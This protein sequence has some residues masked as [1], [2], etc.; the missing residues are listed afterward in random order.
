MGAFKDHF[1]TVAGNYAEFR[2]D[3]PRELFQWIAQQVSRRERVWDCATGNGQA[4]V[5]LK[6][7]FDEVVATDA[8]AGQI[9]SARQLDGV[10]YTVGSAE[11]SGLADASVDC[12]SVAQAAHWF[13]L[14]KFYAEARRVLRPVGLL[15][16]WC[17]GKF[18]F[19]LD[20]LDAAIE[21]FYS[22]VVG[23]YWPPERIIIEQDYRTLEFPLREIAAP[24]FH[25]QAE[26]TLERLAGYFRTWSATQRFVKAQEFDPVIELEE[27]L[28]NCWPADRKSLRAVHWPIHV[29]AGRFE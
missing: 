18:R 28:R 17:Y 22:E 1:S 7:F 26:F 4:A 9:G 19:D 15:A 8:S 10:R 11:H 21:H 23:P 13:D 14:P 24:I 29:R 27:K 3:Y 2:P 25:M 12:V 20:E 16:V 5:L 6:E